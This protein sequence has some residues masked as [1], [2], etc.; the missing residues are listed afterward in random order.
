MDASAPGVLSLCVAMFK[1]DTRPPR[2]SIAV[3]YASSPIGCSF[4]HSSTHTTPEVQVA[5][6]QF[7]RAIDGIPGSMALRL[8]HALRHE[9]NCGARAPRAFGD[10]KDLWPLCNLPD[11]SCDSP[12]SSGDT[13]RKSSR[14]RR[15]YAIKVTREACLKLCA[16]DRLRQMRIH[17]GARALLRRSLHRMSR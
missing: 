7:R 4:L 15:G 8:R 6:I 11:L 14:A 1:L 5:P 13:R 17:S 3:L 12:R 16:I 2:S 10:I 9:T